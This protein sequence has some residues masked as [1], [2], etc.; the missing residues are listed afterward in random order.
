MNRSND[1]SNTGSMFAL[2]GIL[3]ASLLAGYGAFVG[4]GE[5]FRDSE[6]AAWIKVVVSVS[7]GAFV[8]AATSVVR[9]RLKESQEENLGDVEL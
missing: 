6:V 7:I 9:E 5:M 4:L 3:A 2:I 8:L 1:G